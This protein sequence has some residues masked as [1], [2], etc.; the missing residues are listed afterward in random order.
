MSKQFQKDLQEA[1]KAEQ[2]V[3]N[4]L[5]ALTDEYK[6]EYVADDKEFYH[7]GDILAIDA[8]GNKT[9]IEVKND[10]TIY[11]TGNVLCEEENY[12]KGGNYYAK[13]NIHSD[14]EIYCIVSQEE[15]KIYVIDFKVLKAHYKQ[16]DYAQKNHI[17]QIS[18]FYLL[19]L[20]RV[21]QY[22]GLLHTIK[23]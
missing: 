5:A 4:T 2:L 6:F 19:P 15:R 14:Y 9:F 10:G 12:F 17:D 18:Y 8:S 3:L 11:K 1:K 22:G 23:Y 7:K 20:G 16:G 13:G 21:K